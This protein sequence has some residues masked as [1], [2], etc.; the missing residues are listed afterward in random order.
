[1]KWTRKTLGQENQKGMAI[2]IAIFTVVVIMY[3]VTEITYD[4]NVEYIVNANAVS[5]LKAY[6]AAKSGMEISLLRIKIFT[7]IQKQFGQSASASQKKL[8]DMIWNFPFTW[9]PMV[10]PEASGVDKDMIKDKVKESK[11]DSTYYA[12]I[13]DEGSKIDINDLGSPSKGLRDLTKKLLLQIFENRM[14]NDEEWSRKNRDL[15]YGEVIN[16]IIDWE[17]DDQQAINGGD[18]KQA[19]ADLK[20][21][22]LPPNR[23][24]RTVE[25]LRM[26]AGMTDEIFGMLRDRV[27]VYGM[28]AINPN[29]AS[30]EVLKALDVSMTDAVV[31]KVIERRNSEKLGGPYKDDQDFW[32]H[33][34]AEGGRVSAENQKLIVLNFSQVINFRIKSVGEFANVTREIEAVV[35]DFSSVATNMASQSLK[36]AQQ[37]ANPNGGGGAPADKGKDNAN[38]SNDPL[39]KGAPRIVYFTER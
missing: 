32:N 38:N 7:K 23:A 26:V 35:F 14:A 1:M 19:Y 39:P 4:S 36:D 24:F 21:E 29:Y 9:P 8:L 3:L 33:V 20:S 17:D 34:N 5:R 37:A 10:P 30:S 16:N 11:M 25:E 18:E 12:N 27:T 22:D 6:Y 2:M 31:N 13:V 28:H 15:K